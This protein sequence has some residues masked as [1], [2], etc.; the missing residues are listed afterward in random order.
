MTPPKANL[1]YLGLDC[2]LAMKRHLG[3]G[4][5]QQPHQTQACSDSLA[6]YSGLA[7]QGVGGVHREREQKAKIAV[8]LYCVVL[9]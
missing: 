2:S 1:Q 4:M 9:Y 5:S 6:E 8:C 7:L 3:V